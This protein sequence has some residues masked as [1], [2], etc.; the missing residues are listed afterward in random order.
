MQK[1]IGQTN[2]VIA[3]LSGNCGVS[4]RVPIGV[5]LFEFKFLDALLRKL[6]Y[7]I[8]IVFR[9]KSSIASAPLFES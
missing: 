8:D 5:I 1:I 9:I 7:S 4:L 6:N 3:I 2:R